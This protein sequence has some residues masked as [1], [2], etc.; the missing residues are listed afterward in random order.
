MK[1]FV[2]ADIHGSLKA[3]KQVFSRAKFDYDKDKLI[4]LGDVN[5]GWDETADVIEELLK[6]KN[7]IFIMGNHESWLVN[8]LEKKETPLIWTKQGGEATI[9]SYK[10][11]CKFKKKHLEFLK[12]C[13]YYFIDKENRC[14][15][16]GGIKS[17]EHPSKTPV[18]FLTW[19][20][21]MWLNRYSNMTDDKFGDYEE[22]FI[23][24]TSI[25][26]EYKK[27]TR[28]GNVWFMDTGGGFEGKLSMMDLESKRIFQS[29]K[30]DKL[31]KKQVEKRAED[32]LNKLLSNIL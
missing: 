26:Y 27:P 4:F 20:R 18:S 31:H 16:H 2:L 32:L 15:V 1:T 10:G 28:I 12:A 29:D 25:Y 21:D 24:H 9:Q 3:L 30:V 23:G 11:K 17:R 14:F 19:D 5:D 6:I 7:L 8:W 22:V 13:P